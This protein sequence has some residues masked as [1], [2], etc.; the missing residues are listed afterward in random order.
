MSQ[1]YNNNNNK[2]KKTE[3]YCKIEI[4]KYLIIYFCSF[5]CQVEERAQKCAKF[6]EKHVTLQLKFF[7]LNI[8]A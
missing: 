6:V 2:K 7:N 3:L 1:F 8:I 5:T 4:K